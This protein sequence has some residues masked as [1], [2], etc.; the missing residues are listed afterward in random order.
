LQKQIKSS[1]VARVG[2]TV[3][4]VSDLIDHPSLMIFISSQKTYATSSY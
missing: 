4:V 1:A 2:P 3:L